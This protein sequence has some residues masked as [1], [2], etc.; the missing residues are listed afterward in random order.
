MSKLLKKILSASILPAALMIV[1]KVVGMILVN[2]IFD[3]GWSIQSDTGSLFSVQIVYPSP[4]SALK[5]NSLSNLFMFVMLFGGTAVTIFQGYFLHTSHQNPKVLIKLVQFDFLIW[6]SDSPSI[7]PH[8]ATW[9]TFL[10]ISTII[11]VAQTLQSNSY[12]WISLFSIVTSIILTWLAIRD[13]ERE[14]N[15]YLP[16]SD[17]LKYD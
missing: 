2:W 6:L 10:W 15:K 16:E 11:I 7:F 13:F 1:S 4:D 17:K 14:I 12:P 8:M 5:C 9:T 3:L